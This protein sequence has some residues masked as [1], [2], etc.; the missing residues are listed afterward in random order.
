MRSLAPTLA[1]ALLT[2]SALAQT[3]ESPIT[4]ANDAEEGEYLID[5]RGLALYLFKA[6]TKGTATREAVVTCI[7]DCLFTWPPLLVA[8]TPVRAGAV[9]PD[10]LGTVKLPDGTLQATYNGW[11]LY[12]FIDD[13]APGD[14]NGHDIES[15]GEE[16]YLVG[17]DGERARGDGHGGDGDGRDENDD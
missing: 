1:L 17:P 12:Y 8:E 2:A 13:Y 10:L 4:T 14:I 15:F 9:R 16:W 6:D 11:P 7:E 3:G 5:G